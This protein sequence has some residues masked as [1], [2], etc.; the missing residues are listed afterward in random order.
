MAFF[1]PP[2]PL[3]GLGPIHGSNWPLEWLF[4]GEAHN[5]VISFDSARRT[6]S[7]CLVFGSGFQG[8]VGFGAGGLVSQASDKTDS[9]KSWRKTGTAPCS[10]CSKRS[11]SACNNAVISIRNVQDATES[12]AVLPA[13]VLRA[14]V[15]EANGRFGGVEA[16]TEHQTPASC[17]RSC[18]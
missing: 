6:N 12:S 4:P 17:R 9:A 5:Q 2:L 13:E 10:I 11:F 14:F 1:C 15:T 3:V 18:F 16:A 8:H 7:C